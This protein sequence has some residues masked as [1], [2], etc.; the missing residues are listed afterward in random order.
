MTRLSCYSALLFSLVLTSLLVQAK[1]QQPAQREYNKITQGDQTLVSYVWQDS[2]KTEYY[3]KASLDTKL[4]LDAS[5]ALQQFKPRH[6]ARS[7]NQAVRKAEVDLP[8][9][10][11]LRLV[12]SGYSYSVH[13]DGRDADDIKQAKQILRRLI[14]QTENQYLKD[15][16]LTKFQDGYGMQGI[17]PDH[18]YYARANQQPLAPLIGAFYKQVHQ[19]PP[20]IAIDRIIS[21][22]QAIPYSSLDRIESSFI[23]PA[24]VIF[25]NKG[26]CDSKA[27]LAI[28]LIRG[29]Y[30]RR[31]LAI[32][33]LKKHALLAVNFGYDVQGDWF[34]HEGERWLPAEVAGPSVLA[35]GKTSIQSSRELAARAFKLVPVP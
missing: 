17:I 14:N 24:S 25:D 23:S 12:N 22:V 5:R 11:N 21:F 13:L 9:G 3:V 20:H 18:L 10:V 26:D 1:T 34:N 29:V 8:A 28:A 32:V 19:L 15:R 4:M 2:R 7:L 35:I 6:L 27:A 31:K 33:Y 16:H 30:P